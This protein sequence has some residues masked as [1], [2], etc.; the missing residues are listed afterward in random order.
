MVD[1]LHEMTFNNKMITHSTT[2]TRLNTSTYNAA[3]ETNTKNVGIGY[4]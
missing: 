2:K 3:S 4:N 1:F